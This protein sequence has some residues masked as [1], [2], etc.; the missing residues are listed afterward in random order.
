[1]E[2][3]INSL[4]TVGGWGW[5]TVLVFKAN[6]GNSNAEKYGDITPAVHV[7]Q[8]SWWGL[9]FNNA[10]NGNS[11]FYF[12][13]FSIE[14]KR[15]YSIV[16]EQKPEKG[17]VRKRDI[18]MVVEAQAPASYDLYQWHKT[19]VD[20]HVIAEATAGFLTSVFVRFTSLLRWMGKRFVALKTKKPWP[21]KM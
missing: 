12:S 16:L 13:H 10:V 15:W 1:M 17:K 5:T 20:D 14:L 7:H 4:V 9:L 11:N 3:K 21:S 6:G 18:D 8:D 2:L 19:Y